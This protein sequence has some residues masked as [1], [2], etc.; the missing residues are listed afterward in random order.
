MNSFFKFSGIS[1]AALGAYLFFK[2]ESP[3]EFVYRSKNTL[4]ETI[5][6]ISN[7]NDKKQQLDDSVKNLNKEI[8]KSKNTLN[9]VNKDIER[10][11]FKVKP[12]I[13]KINEKVN[14]LNHKFSH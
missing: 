2:K 13:Q 1:L 10:F 7:W 11:E 4:D 6:D 5:T 9:L 12:H 8:L 3:K 14:E